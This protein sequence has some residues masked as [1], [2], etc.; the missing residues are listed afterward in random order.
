VK[1]WLTREERRA[2]DR[3]ARRALRRHRRETWRAENPDRPRIRIRWDKL[4]DLAEEIIEDAM[5]DGAIDLEDIDDAIDEL[6]ASLDKWIE[7]ESLGPVG[8]AL[9]LGTDILIH[10]LAAGIVKRVVR[11]KLLKV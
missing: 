2:L 4:E 3:P 7:F 1:T 9:E 8:L 6:A 11:E 5:E 10:Q